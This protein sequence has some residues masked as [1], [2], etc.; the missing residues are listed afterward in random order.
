MIRSAP[1]FVKDLSFLSG[2]N[3]ERIRFKQTPRNAFGVKY[4]TSRDAYLDHK[5]KRIVQQ[6]TKA[7]IRTERAESIRLWNRQDE[8]V[9]QLQRVRTPESRRIQREILTQQLALKRSSKSRSSP[10]MFAARSKARF[11][12]RKAS[13]NVSEWYIFFALLRA[14]LSRLCP[15][16]LCSKHRS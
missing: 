11:D 5:Y 6:E 7:V 12:S 1:R 13:R 14:L 10:G 15:G 4:S 16:L 3:C 2:A 9:H 8:A